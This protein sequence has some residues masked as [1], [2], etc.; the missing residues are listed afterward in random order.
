MDNKW[1]EKDPY[2]LASQAQ[3]VFYVNDPKLGS[4][5]KVVQKLLHRHI[6]DVP[7][8]T[9]TNNS[10]NDNQ[11]PTIKEAVKSSLFHLLHRLL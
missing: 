6:F 4:S 7:K 5:W 10:E 3:Q 1:Y 8:Q 11:D 2:V 9:T